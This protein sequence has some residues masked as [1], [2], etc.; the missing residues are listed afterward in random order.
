VAIRDGAAAGAVVSIRDFVAL[1]RRLARWVGKAHST[2]GA[3]L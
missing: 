2:D 3:V 1:D